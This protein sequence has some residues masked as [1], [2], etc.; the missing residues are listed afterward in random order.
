MSAER[1]AIQHPLVQKLVARHIMWKGIDWACSSEDEAMAN[2][3]RS[4]T[5]N[6]DNAQVISSQQRPHH[7]FGQDIHRPMLDFDF[8]VALVPSSTPGHSHLY[9]DRQLTWE[10]YEKLLTVMAEI[11]LLEAGYV[12]ASKRRRCTFLRLPWVKKGRE[13]ECVPPSLADVEA[14]LAAEPVEVPAD[15][16]WATSLDVPF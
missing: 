14:F 1:L 2:D 12:E 9:M 4:A 11:G 3:Q 16:P 15:D 8:P 6:V 5:Y 10:Q 13:A 7:S